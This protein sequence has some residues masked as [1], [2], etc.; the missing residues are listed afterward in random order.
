V[1]DLVFLLIT[2]G[3]ITFGMMAVQNG[4]QGEEAEKARQWERKSRGQA[5]VVSPSVSPTPTP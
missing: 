4:Y 1:K 5:I 3:L 2:L